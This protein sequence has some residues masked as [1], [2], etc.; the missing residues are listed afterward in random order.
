MWLLLGRIFSVNRI[1]AEFP[2]CIYIFKCSSALGFIQSLVFPYYHRTSVL[3]YAWH[4]NFFLLETI[5]CTIIKGISL[6][7]DTLLTP[8]ETFSV[9]SWK[10]KSQAV[11]CANSQEQH[12]SSCG[13]H[14]RCSSASWHMHVQSHTAGPTLQLLAACPPENPSCTQ[15]PSCSLHTYWGMCSNTLSC[16]FSSSLREERVAVVTTLLWMAFVTNKIQGDTSLSPC[17]FSI[18]RKGIC[19]VTQDAG[20]NNFVSRVLFAYTEQNETEKF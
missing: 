17:L 16:L 19:P 4:F 20:G 7:W 18:Y 2:I 6:F 3:K 10:L 1:D 9:L 11:P 13:R 8:A 12:A 14:H 15:P 5:F